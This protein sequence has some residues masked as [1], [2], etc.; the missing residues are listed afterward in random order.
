MTSVLFL[1][2]V[3]TAIFALTLTLS[4]GTQPRR[5]QTILIL[6]ALAGEPLQLLAYVSDSFAVGG[7]PEV[8]GDLAA[9]TDAAGERGGNRRGPYPESPT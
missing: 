8:T 3:G 7:G 6:A 1:A 9:A 5:R 2:L 4:Q